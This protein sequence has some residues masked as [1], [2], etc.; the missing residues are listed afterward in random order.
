MSPS[1]ERPRRIRRS[2]EQAEQEILDAAEAFLQDHD[3]RELTVDA[4]MR[5]T[6]M[7]RS[8]FYNYFADRNEL[9]LRLIEPIAEEMMEAARPWLDD[10]GDPRATLAAGLEQVVAIYARH[11]RLLRAVHEASYHDQGIERF[12]RELLIDNFVE[13]VARRLRR[14]RRAGRTGITRPDDIARAL[15]TLNVNVMFERL[16]RT[17][18]DPPRAVAQTLR[19][20]WERTVYG[21]PD[22]AA[23]PRGRRTAV[24]ATAR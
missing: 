19:F 6:G 7:R 14:E 11:G 5:G 17:P 13:A 8:G 2:P 10:E 3:F 20:V 15:L 21:P 4:L 9:T 12:Y 1:A 18:S 24:S 23:A 22:E 16:G